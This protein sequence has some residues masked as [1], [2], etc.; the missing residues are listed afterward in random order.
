VDK[1]GLWRVTDFGNRSE[2]NGMK[3]IEFVMWREQLPYYDA[4]IFIEQCI[5][6]HQVAAGDFKRLK[7]AAE[8]DWREVGPTD[9]KGEYRFTFKARPSEKDLSAIGRYVT[10]EHLDYFNCK[11]VEAYE[12]VGKSKKLNKDVVHIFRATD[13]YPIF[14]FDYGTF[15]KLYKPH[16]MEKRHRFMY[17]DIGDK[18][19]NFVF[20]LHQIKHAKNEFQVD[21]NAELK[22][23]EE[24]EDARV[25]DLFRCSGESDALNLYS[26]GFHV[27][28]LNSET[29]DLDYRTY[30]MIDNLCQ[31]HYQI[32]DLDP[33]GQHEALK[34]ALK[35]IKL[36][37]IELPKWL[38]GKKDWRGNSC[39]DL[40]DFINLAGDDYDS[41]N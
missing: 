17:I 3:A 21:E 24:K 32:M 18:P 37:T 15:K 38:Q 27:Y 33:T 36:F 4:L 30:K 12:F 26:L 16:E 40:K 8:Y 39:K 31:N 9:K 2:I 41:N 19:K 20:G 23:P 28:W 13:D 34:N 7:W 6:N 29:E 11:T 5:L 1:G 10:D 14:L 22:T 35:H 25:I